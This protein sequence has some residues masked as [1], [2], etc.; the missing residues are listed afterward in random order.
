MSKPYSILL[1]SLTAL[2]LLTCAF[3]CS[4][5]R[6]QNPYETEYDP[7]Y[8]MSQDDIRAHFNLHR[9]RWWNHYK[10]GLWFLAG[11]HYAAAREDFNN[12]IKER[13]HDE[14]N[15][16]TYGMHFIDYFPHRERGIAFYLEGKSETDMAVKE[17]LFRDAINELKISIEQEA[18][19]KAKFYLKLATS[20]FWRT[21][22]EDITPPVVAIAN[23]TIDRWADVPTL[24]I[25]RYAATLEIIT[26]DHQSGIAAVWVDDR[27]L[28][29]ES[30][31]EDFNEPTVVAIDSQDK[32]RTVIVK[33]VDLA[34]NESRPATVRLVVDTTSP[35]AAIRVHPDAQSLLGG[36][37]PVEIVAVDDRGLKSIQLGEDPYD[38]RKCRGQVTWE[39]TF[40]ARPGDREL[41]VKVADLAG[42]VTAT[43]ITIEPGRLISR[44]REQY[45]FY[46]WPSLRYNDRRWNGVFGGMPRH[47]TQWSHLVQ[48]YPA[49]SHIFNTHIGHLGVQR[50]LSYQARPLAP[51]LVFRDF[52]SRI[53]ARTSYD[54]YVLQGE[55]RHA[56]GLESIK[57]TVDGEELK[58][59]RVAQKGDY[60]IF[61]DC[62]PLPNYGQ[63]RSIA[64]EASFQDGTVIS[65]S[66]L[67]VERVPNCVYEPNAV[68]S[69]FLLPLEEKSTPADPNGRYRN[70]ERAHDVVLDALRACRLHDPDDPKQSYPRFNCKVLKTWN[71]DKM[72]EELSGL[73]VTESSPEMKF[74]KLADKYQDEQALQV[75]LGFFGDITE[76]ADSLEIVLRV[77]D[78]KNKELLFRKIDIF[79]NKGDY[80]WCTNGLIAKLQKT[81]R[82]VHGEITDKT[83]DGV[84]VIDRGRNDGVFH[85]MGVGIY[86][87]RGNGC[88]E[89]LGHTII[90]DVRRDSSAIQVEDRLVW[91]NIRNSSDPI[92]VISK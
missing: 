36:H 90:K 22:K 24:Y 77:I 6:L 25:N 66:D 45:L 14:E 73:R 26:S 63:V 2:L 81:I 79:G 47:G 7:N 35:T 28:F 68:Y 76:D 59:K 83:K 61:S 41:A 43:S 15:A 64:V 4:I 37:I 88:F 89:S 71:A 67:R 13:D 54:T 78:V 21:T 17:K 72:A 62:V 92:D 49:K 23:S 10:R 82:R 12:T 8:G 86:E 5:A 70:P 9:G 48:V 50:L 91:N 30:V 1:G 51:E 33:A 29:I 40:Y 27:R 42:N 60:L 56:R 19:S 34:G 57:I 39:G 11:H 31:K 85:R 58:N 75:Y 74:T 38:S 55:V 20:G 44:Q 80:A 16:R 52:R 65:K 18:S 32:T 87:R 53:T 69:I 46:D 3:G 84:I